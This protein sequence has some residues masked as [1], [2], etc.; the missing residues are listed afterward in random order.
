MATDYTKK[1]NL[2]YLNKDFEGFKA[3]LIEHLKVYFPDFNN[4]FNEGSVGMMFLEMAS[5]VGDNLSYY[6]DKKFQESFIETAT[7]RKNVFKQ[8]KQLGYKAFGKVSAV[9][10]VNATIE[11]PTTTIN[12]DILPNMSYAGKI[13][14]GAKLKGDNGKIYE[15]LVEVNFSGS[16]YEVGKTDTSGN[17]T[18]FLLRQNDVDIRQGE[19]KTTTV[20]VGAYEAF[21]KI[22]LTDDDVIEIIEVRDAESNEWY[23]VEYLAQDTVFVGEANTSE[24]TALVP[25]VLKLRSVPYRFVSEYDVDTGKMSLIFGTGESTSF[26][27]DLIPD[28]GELALPLYGKDYFTDFAIDPQNFLKTRTMGLAPANT[29]LTIKYR[30]GGGVDSNAGSNTIRSVVEKT[31]TVGDTSLNSAT[32]RDV[33]NSFS[34]NNPRPIIGGLDEKPLEE[35]KQ[36]ISANFNAQNRMVTLPDFTIRALTMP[37]RYGSVFRA[38]AKLNNFTSN[39]VDLHVLTKNELGHVTTPTDDLRENLKKYLSK[40]RMATDVINILDGEVI[41][42]GLNFQILTKP[43]YNTDEV[44]SDCIVVLK[45]YFNIDKWQINQ[46]INISSVN[47]LIYDID[48]VLSV[49]ELQFIQLTGNRDGRTYSDAQGYNINDNISNGIIYCKDNSIF[50]VK[51]ADVDL[52]G[53]SL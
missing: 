29:T 39:A 12:Q 32:I 52:A 23:E 16:S 35:V 53:S 1:R 19:T 2:K 40:Y 8:A 4:D 9:G 31:F 37:S 50:E 18:T 13:A 30:V 44:L 45:D 33:G 22:T 38:Y 47:N 25:Y 11:V 51:Y 21:R 6:L 7:E 28:L 17:P 34:V 42:I 5:F 27:G 14:R 36:L 15:T 46:P 49:V 3:D 24:N 43:E 10:K 41:N 48:G 20:S 26:D